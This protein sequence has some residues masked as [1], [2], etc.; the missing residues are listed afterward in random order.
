MKKSALKTEP[1]SALPNRAALGR[2]KLFIGLTHHGDVIRELGN[3]MEPGS[4]IADDTH[5]YISLEVRQE[6]ADKIR[7]LKIILSHEE[8]RMCHACPPGIIRI[9]PV[10]G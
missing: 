1:C 8:F 6:L 4:L 5:P 2:S 7:T 10:S 3:F 9:F